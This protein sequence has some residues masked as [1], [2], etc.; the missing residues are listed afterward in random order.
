MLLKIRKIV[1]NNFTANKDGRNKRKHHLVLQKLDAFDGNVHIEHLSSSAELVN[2]L[3]VSVDIES[4][5]FDLRELLGVPAIV[6]DLT[7]CEVQHLL[8]LKA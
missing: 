7:H 6:F 8:K 5:D 3:G 2:L 4:V 1:G